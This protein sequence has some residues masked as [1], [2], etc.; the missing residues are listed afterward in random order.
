MIRFYVQENCDKRGRIT[1]YTT[2]KKLGQDKIIYYV[3]ENL[4][5]IRFCT[6]CKKTAKKG[7]G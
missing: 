4:G 1:F 2:C 7:A 5:R 3:Q 6:T